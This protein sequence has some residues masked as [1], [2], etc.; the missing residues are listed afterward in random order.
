MLF[1]FCQSV[2]RQVHNCIILEMCQLAYMTQNVDL[3][4][5]NNQAKDNHRLTF[6]ILC[7]RTCLTVI[8][9]IGFSYVPNT[10]VIVM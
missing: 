5:D 9:L 2:V 10:Y 4:D 3:L 6:Y 8:F 7:L 1:V